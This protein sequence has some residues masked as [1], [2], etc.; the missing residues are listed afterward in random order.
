MRVAIQTN[1]HFTT[2]QIST[3]LICTQPLYACTVT[4]LL[5]GVK[6]GKQRSCPHQALGLQDL[7]W[8]DRM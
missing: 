4:H 2:L 3:V 8:T 1:G 6:D 5:N 7:L